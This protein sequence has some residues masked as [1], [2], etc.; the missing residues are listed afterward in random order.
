MKATLFKSNIVGAT[1]NLLNCLSI[2][3]STS[4]IEDTLKE[5][6]DYPSLS[7]IS[8]VLDDF[9]I[10]N[11]AVKIGLD[12]LKKVPLPAI[13]C[14]HFRGDMKFVVLLSVSTSETISYLDSNTGMIQES[15]LEF[16]R[17][18][19][20][21]LLLAEAGP[22]SRSTQNDEIS[23]RAAKTKTDAFISITLLVVCFACVVTMSTMP[24]LLIV[25]LVLKIIG[26]GASMLL[27]T[28]DLGL[29][30][31]FSDSFC[32][33]GGA[34]N[35]I[36]CD[37][38]ANSKAASF[39]GIL[40]MSELGAIYFTGG[41]IYIIAIGDVGEKYVALAYLQMVTIL[42]IPYTVFSVYYQLRVVRQVCPLCMLVILV[43]WAELI[44][45]LMSHTSLIPPSTVSL[46]TL[47][48]A[49]IVPATFWL[50]VRGAV[51]RAINSEYLKK[52]L[53]YFTAS[54]GA[55]RAVLHERQVKFRGELLNKISI[56]APDKPVTVTA[57]LSLFCGPCGF[58]FNEI[59]S[60]AS[61]YEY[62]AINII[63]FPSGPGPDQ[64][65]RTVLER[66]VLSG[67]SAAIAYLQHWYNHTINSL[68]GDEG[69]GSKEAD[70]KIDAI[71]SN[72]TEW[73]RVNEISSTP[74]IYINN[75]MKPTGI[76]LKDLDPLFREMANIKH[77]TVEQ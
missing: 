43:L 64:I 4:Y 55:L 9:N 61:R 29:S 8:S 65:T 58:A 52:T 10:E 35:V 77:E 66:K 11:V 53:K 41:L 75:A 69:I 1:C 15:I 47:I 74:R 42:A 33:L 16:E 7:A 44:T 76:S 73:L 48:M 32:T 26:V 22:D 56:N 37:R 62:L 31:R 24:T 20:G 51:S 36:G 70:E 57:V 21:V 30:S 5:H 72:W 60:L 63:L 12:Q 40:R 25:L 14:L 6:K 17:K 38:V 50:L 34:N 54:P 27:L 46:P 19:S 2:P 49:F 13:A 59:L 39:F 71:L 68:A 28:K 3:Y 45:V 67:D 23:T 18:W